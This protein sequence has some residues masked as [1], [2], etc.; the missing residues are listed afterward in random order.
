MVRNQE[1]E[2]NYTPTFTKVRDSEGAF[3]SEAVNTVVKTSI[4]K[5][6]PGPDTLRVECSKY[7]NAH[8]RE[9]LLVPYNAIL[10]EGKYFESLN[11]ANTV[12]I[13]KKGDPLK[14]ENYRPVAL[15]QT[16]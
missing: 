7:L 8:N 3:V 1:I 16:F 15:L 14:I 13:Y 5:N 6:A 11:L 9:A 2:E 12:S 4:S 10:C